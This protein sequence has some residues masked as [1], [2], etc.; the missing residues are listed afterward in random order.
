MCNA[1]TIKDVDTKVGH[2]GVTTL[3]STSFIVR[4]LHTFLSYRV[5]ELRQGNKE[6]RV[7]IGKYI[8]IRSVESF[9][10]WEPFLRAVGA[11]SGEGC[12]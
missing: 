6:T 4:A 8:G 11:V 5:F 10:S 12:G 9:N 7:R 2:T 3:V 1:L